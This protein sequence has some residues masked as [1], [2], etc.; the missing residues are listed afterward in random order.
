MFDR[1]RSAVTSVDD[2]GSFDVGD[3]TLTVKTT[4]LLPTVPFLAQIGNEQVLVTAISGNNW[5]VTR[6]QNGTAQ[7]SHLDRASVYILRNAMDQNANSL[8]NEPVVFASSQTTFIA[9]ITS[10]DTTM[11]VASSAGFN[12]VATPFVV[13]IEDEQVLVTNIAGTTWTIDRGWNGT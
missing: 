1:Q 6:A 3:T 9:A 12:S 13:Q 4:G 5:T 7:A 10:T 11:F 8:T 2:S